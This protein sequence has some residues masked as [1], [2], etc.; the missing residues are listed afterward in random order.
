M[1]SLPLTYATR[2]LGAPK[3]WDH[4]RD[5]L[6]HTLDICDRDGWMISAWTP[7]AAELKR[8]NEG[9]PVFLHI[10]GVT[11]PVVSLHVPEP[12]PGAAVT[13]RARS[14]AIGSEGQCLLCGACQGVRGRCRA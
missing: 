6:C 9:L 4:E 11:H 5:G 12:T 13:C 14:N 10:Q 1:N 2:R 3:N 7:S 8:L